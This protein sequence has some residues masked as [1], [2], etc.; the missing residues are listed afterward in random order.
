MTTKKNKIAPVELPN[1]SQQALEGLLKQQR[2][3]R[4][5]IY[6]KLDDI[7]DRIQMLESR[8]NHLTTAFPNGDIPGHRLYH[9]LMIEEIADRK[10]LIKAIKEKALSSLVWS[11]LV[12]LGLM[13]WHEIQRRL[14]VPQ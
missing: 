9:E 10:R 13:A 7:G 11:A 12:A 14:G 4:E 2:Q 8:I 6:G 1:L 3:A 5:K